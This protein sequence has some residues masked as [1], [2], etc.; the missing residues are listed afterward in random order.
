MG[1]FTALRKFVTY[2]TY[3]KS[4]DTGLYLHR[5]IML[6]GVWLL[7]F[8]FGMSVTSLAPLVRPITDELEM[9]Y[10]EMGGILGSWQLVYIFTALPCGVLIDRLGLRY[11][12]LIASV[13]IGISCMMRALAQGQLTL[14]LAVAFF[15]IG[16]P[17]ISIGAPKL[18][19][20]WFK[21]DERRLAMG[22]YITGPALG[23]IT[24]LSITNSVMMP[25]M[26]EDWRKVLLV[27]SFVV[28]FS[29][30]IW[31]L[32]S[33]HPESLEMEN[34]LNKLER[35]PQIKVF[36]ELFNLIPVRVI[37][38]MGICIFLYNH[39]L[40]NWMYEILQTRGL[41]LERSGYWASIPTVIGILGSL[42]IPKMASPKFR[43][44]ILAGLFVSAGTSVILL[45]SNSETILLIGLALKGITQG[46]MMTILL[47]ILMEIPKVGSRYFGSAGGLVFASA[48]IGGVLGPLSIGILSNIEGSFQSGLTM[49]SLV[50]IV[51]FVLVFVLKHLLTAQQ[52]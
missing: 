18:I 36:L 4:D 52:N 23:S 21:E 33:R 11:S 22:I 1:L 30:L 16:G 42:S 8:C 15:G 28:F 32:I 47:L 45:K 35:S 26:D 34:Q 44:W 5:W 41:G 39:G 51:L 7:Y 29:G 50:C 14:F 20:I 10:A 27:Y 12:L 43:F 24:T 37:M 49:L 13:L 40:S 6:S 31:L 48:E 9:N 38:L 3:Q 46:S 19:S 17:L 25:W 2:M